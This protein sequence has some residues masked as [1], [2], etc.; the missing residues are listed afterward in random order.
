MVKAIA[1]RGDQRRIIGLTGGIATGKSTVG[2]ILTTVHHLPVVDAD[3]FSRAALAPGTAATQAVLHR[4]G[5]AVRTQ[6]GTVNRRAL[7][8]IVFATMAERRWLEQLIHPQVRQ[9]LL[10]ALEKHKETDTVVLMVPLLFEAGLDALC[11]E[12]W[13]VDLDEQ[14]QQQRLQQRD[15]LTTLEVND[16]LRA[17]WPMARKRR[18]ATVVL[19]NRGDRRALQFRIAA[20]LRAGK[21]DGINP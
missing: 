4:Y 12:T 14:T 16:R 21:T 19:D 15:Q 17:Q 2:E 10:A 9:A 18:L 6:A 3:R 5:P 13:L 1:R 8:R 20:A 11:S 7:A